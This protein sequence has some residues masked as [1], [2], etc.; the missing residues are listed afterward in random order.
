MR[1]GR[2]FDAITLQNLYGAKGAVS[3]SLDPA[4]LGGPK[5]NDDIGKG[6]LCVAHRTA[7][8]FLSAAT[9]LA[10]VVSG[11]ASGGLHDDPP[12]TLGQYLED[13]CRAS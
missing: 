6:N 8:A 5:V 4:R 9:E 10:R 11:D 3:L 13:A 7:S 12:V 1:L 2:R